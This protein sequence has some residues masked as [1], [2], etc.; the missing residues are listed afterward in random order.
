M[1]D[2]TQLG[3]AGAT[4]AILFF[5]IRYFVASLDKKD[6]YI[7]E[8]ISEFQNHVEIC[9]NNFM[10]FG[11]HFAKISGKQTQALNNLITKVEGLNG[12]T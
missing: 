7:K 6:A 4:L 11:D 5:I 2:Y 10:K 8:M 1:Q 12:R 3:V 9:N